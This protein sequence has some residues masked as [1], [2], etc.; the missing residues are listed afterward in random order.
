MSH[1]PE[2][3]A[4][5]EQ[6]T[7]HILVAA[8]P[9]GD[10]AAPAPLSSA[11]Q[12]ETQ[13]TKRAPSKHQAAVTPRPAPSTPYALPVPSAPIGVPVPSPPYGTPIPPEMRSA[14]YIVAAPSAP[15]SISSYPPRSPL[16]PSHPHYSSS[17]PPPRTTSTPARTT[18]PPPPV[19]SEL[20][21]T[22]DSQPGSRWAG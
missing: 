18:P 7:Q 10:S 15:A 22:P 19:R 4:A 3:A 11:S 12:A 13:P 8:P 9:A 17:V 1:R 2:R 20:P 5:R 14:P 21:T 6:A 16:P